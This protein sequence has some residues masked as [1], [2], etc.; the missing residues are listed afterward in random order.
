M[1][2]LTGAELLVNG[3]FEAGLAGW[4][5]TDQANSSGSIFPVSGAV[6]PISGF[7]TV[8]PH[9][10]TTYAVSDQTGGGAHSLS[11]SFIV[12]A[13][14]AGQSVIL[15]FWMFVNDQSGAGPIVGAC[16]LD[17]I[18]CGPNQHATVDLMLA[19]TPELG[20]APVLTNFYLGVDP[21][22]NPHPY[23]FYSFDITPLVAG[24]GA[25]KVR[26][27]EVDNQLWFNQGIDDVSVSL[28]GIPEPS[29]FGLIAAAL[30]GIRAIRRFRG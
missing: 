4:L 9:S 25:F 13:L 21:G 3:G 1:I 28:T 2:P 22:P 11:Q 27:G 20:A 17:F 29:S 23:T 8:G 18:A 5:V 12:P 6:T 7:A 19:A 15:S 10:G 24:G 14:S 16:G 26:F 30:F